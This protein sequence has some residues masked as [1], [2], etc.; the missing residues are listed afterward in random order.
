ML[1]Q[2]G[3]PISHLKATALAE[4]VR[5]PNKYH[6]TVTL[7]MCTC[8]QCGAPITEPEAQPLYNEKP[9][10]MHANDQ[11]LQIKKDEHTAA[12]GHTE[13]TPTEIHGTRPQKHPRGPKRRTI[14][15][16]Q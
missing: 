2:L 7:L 12:T 9:D 15:D 8:K 13:Y 11:D 6:K 1:T 5:D 16:T 10:W 14:G 4:Y 3:K